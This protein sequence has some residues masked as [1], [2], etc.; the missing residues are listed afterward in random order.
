MSEKF[1]KQRNEQP[2]DNASPWHA[3]L[4]VTP[5]DKLNPERKGLEKTPAEK[6]ESTAAEVSTDTSINGVPRNLNLEEETTTFIST[7]GRKTENQPGVDKQSDEDRIFIPGIDA[8][9][10]VLSR[11]EQEDYQQASSLVQKYSERLEKQVT[12]PLTKEFAE[13]LNEMERNMPPE[14]LLKLEMGRLNFQAS[15][16]AYEQREAEMEKSG[17]LLHLV[18]PERT[19]EMKEF[20]A[21]ARQLLNTLGEKGLQQALALEKEFPGLAEARE[22]LRNY[23]ERIERA[24]EEEAVETREA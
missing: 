3:E 14:E 5:S 24:L 12:G 11:E 6:E 8:T 9:A 16:E 15:K 1:E 19:K 18:E 13:G 23:E 4:Q 22:R 17:K 20:D 2:I 21:K 7:R 10:A